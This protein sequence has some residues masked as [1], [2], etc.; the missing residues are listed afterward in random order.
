MIEELELIEEHI[1]KGIEETGQFTATKGAGVTR[2]PF[3]SEAMKCADYISYKMTELGLHVSQDASGAVIGVMEGRSPERIMIG[4]HLDSVRH[5]GAYD[6]MAGILCGMEIASHYKRN[7]IIPPYTLEIVATNDEEGARFGGGYFSSK[8]FLGMWTVDDLKRNKDRDGISYYEAMRSAGLDPENIRSAERKKEGWKGFVE[9][10]IEQGPV[11]E[12]A[13]K[14]LGIVSAIVAMERFYVTITGRADHAGTE[15]MEMRLDAMMEGAKIM[16]RINTYVRAH[17]GMVGTVGEVHL[18]P[19][20]INVVPEKLIFSVDLR[21]TKEEELTACKELIKVCLA[22]AQDK[23]FDTLLTQT[24]SNSVTK[25]K[26]EWME[27][28]AV[29][30]EHLQFSN[31]VMHSGAGHD[32]AVIGK[33]IDTVMLFVPSIGGRS[34]NPDEKSDETVLAKAVLVII[35]F[36]NRI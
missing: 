25:M 11:L 3:T 34:H 17:D 21:S 29:S 19:N 31:M 18:F 8:A 20:E 1:K 5:G 22:K 16:D 14:E 13:E 23:G 4:S 36:L 33:E 12:K 10:H 32:A 28:L 24:L 7:N 9:I 15:P 27:Q 6:G 30:S 35:D 2:L 26:A